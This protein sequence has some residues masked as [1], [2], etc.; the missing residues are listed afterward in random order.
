MSLRRRW[1]W[2]W[3]HSV[4]PSYFL[5]QWE[6]LVCGPPKQ[7]YGW[8]QFFPAD[9]APIIHPYLLV[10]SLHSQLPWTSMKAMKEMILGLIKAS[11]WF[12]QHIWPQIQLNLLL[13]R[14]YSDQIFWNHP[15]PA[16]WPNLHPNCHSDQS[17][18]YNFSL[19]VCILSYSINQL[20]FRSS[21]IFFITLSRSAFLSHSS[22][23][24]VIFIFP[25]IA[26]LSIFSTILCPLTPLSLISYPFPH[27]ISSFFNLQSFT[28]HPLS[29]S[30][31]PGGRGR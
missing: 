20:F 30:C 18:K 10:S 29:H 5:C 12:F 27:P 16:G 31:T 24:F 28:P 9:T 26:P 14:V 22:L 17:E 23:P 15:F 11:A 3:V 4:F 19:D 21:G 1:V 7:V 25:F 2:A 8:A 6:S 13:S